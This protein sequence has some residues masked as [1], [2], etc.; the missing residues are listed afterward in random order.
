MYPAPISSIFEGLTTSS[1][2]EGFVNPLLDITALGAGIGTS[3]GFEVGCG[4]G[5]CDGLAVVGTADIVGAAD[6]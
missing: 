3:E 2:L 5:T 1:A 6:G 4:I